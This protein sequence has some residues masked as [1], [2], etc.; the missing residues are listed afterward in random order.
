MIKDIHIY[1]SRK[2][3]DVQIYLNKEQYMPMKCAV[4][5]T[6]VDCNKKHNK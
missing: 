6:D 3:A 1:Y 4:D 2:G 5:S